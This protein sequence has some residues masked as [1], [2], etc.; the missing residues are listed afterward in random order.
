MDYPYQYATLVLKG[1]GT[2]ESDGQIDVKLDGTKPVTVDAWVRFTE[3]FTRETIIAQKDSF[4]M[5]IDRGRLFFYMEGYPTVYS[6]GRDAVAIISNEWIHLCAVYDTQTVNLYINGI[7]DSYVALSGQGTA[8]SGAFVFG[9]GLSGML[10]QVRIFN[11][12]LNADQVREYMMETDLSDTDFKNILAAYYDFSQIPAK[13]CIKDGQLSLLGDAGQRLISIG[14]KFRGD[15]FLTIDEEP[16]I[17]PAGRGNDSY[18]VQTW[19]LWQPDKLE[20]RQTIFANGDVNGMAGMSLFIEQET[21]YVKGVRANGTQE[22]DVIVSAAAVQAGQWVNIALT[23]ATDTMKLYVNGELSNTLSGLF[24]IPVELYDQQPRIGAEVIENDV[25]GQDWFT[26]FISRLD[27]WNRELSAKEIIQ[28]AAK[29][30]DTDQDGLQAN[31]IFHMRESC[32]NCNGMLLGARNGLRFDEVIIQPAKNLCFTE[33]KQE[34]D[35][36]QETLQPEQLAQFRDQVLSSLSEEQ[37]DRAFYTVTSHMLEDTVYFVVHYKDCSYT[38]CYGEALDPLTQWY[39]ELLL[40][41]LSFV[42]D[43]V[44]GM[45]IQSSGNQLYR[46]LIRAVRHQN[47]MAILARRAFRPEMV[48]ELL[49]ALF[50][51]GLL[52]DILRAALSN[53]RWY[54]IAITVAKFV[55][56]IVSSATGAWAVYYGAL[57]VGLAIEVAVHLN[58]YPGK[59]EK[60]EIQALM[61]SS[62]Y[63]H[64]KLSGDATIPLQLDCEDYIDPLMLPEWASNKTD[65]SHVAYRLDLLG[66]KEVQIQ[67]VFRTGQNE[68][69]TREV[70]CINTSSDKI[71]GDSDTVTVKTLPKDSNPPRITF[72]FKN[73]QLAAKGVNCV[74]TELC[75][76]EKNSQG[77]WQ[78]IAKT[79]HNIYVILQ[80]PTSPWN[81]LELNNKT[82]NPPWVSVLKYACKWAAGATTREQ[83]A[84]KITMQVNGSLK[85]RYETEEGKSAY[86][87]KGQFML[88]AFL[89]QLENHDYSDVVNCTDCATICATFANALGCQLSEKIMANTKSGEGF[90]CNKILAIGY[91]EWKKPFWGGF[92]YHEVCMM[93]PLSP[94]DRVSPKAENNYKVYD[95]CL[96]LDA[97]ANPESDTGRIAYLPVGMRFSKYGDVDKVSSIPEGESYREHLAINGE[98]GIGSCHYYYD[99]NQVNAYIYKLPVSYIIKRKKKKGAKVMYDLASWP[100]ESIMEQNDI[101]AAVNFRLD[102]GGGFRLLK[103]YPMPYPKSYEDV[104]ES[105]ED[106]DIRISIRVINCDS[107]DEAKERLAEHLSQCVALDLPQITNNLST[108]SADIAFGAA[109]GSGKAV[110]AIRGNTLIKIS[111]FGLKSID[112]IP[113]YNDMHEGIRRSIKQRG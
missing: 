54:H 21:G 5:G 63:F 113:L 11:C 88:N 18:T 104:Y 56:L 10:R 43:L 97:S 24:P 35:L 31:Y 103:R 71:F 65:K 57:T 64:H 69:V 29:S 94:D 6:S 99:Y 73:H 45:K 48:L 16:A 92:G 89:S 38:V 33:V 14:A 95:A 1:N 41:I 87:Y 39:V 83:I 110:S 102:S 96:K 53:L 109:D 70:R 106:A 108:C 55:A 59:E 12:A 22:D 8:G 91:T 60:K 42:I 67:A 20:N 100:V 34:D 19:V 25:N 84:E 80:E 2:A 37:N 13:E 47:V 27:I 44:L 77:V 9:E 4:A 76:Q 66:I 32:N 78:D 58:K 86:V 79:K 85:L 7:F 46:V 75:W 3:V 15:S 112:L 81:G 62:V 74:Q 98:T 101:N 111:N 68:E 49:R 23:Y 93:E 61:L 28:Y 36:I 50:Y 107:F 105:E 90:Y 17:N 26:G 52:T 30:P 40:I 51:A 72:T 82:S